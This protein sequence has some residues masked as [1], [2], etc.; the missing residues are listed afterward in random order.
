MVPGLPLVDQAAIIATIDPVSHA[1]GDLNT[2]V[3]DMLTYHR[4]TF[5]LISGLLA[6]GGTLDLTINGDI[7]SG[8]SYA[9]AITGKSTAAATFSGSAG[10]N[11][12]QAVIEI[13]GA[14]IEAQGLRYIRGT[15]T[16]AS[17]G[18]LAAVVVL[19][20]PRYQPATD[21]DLASVAEIVR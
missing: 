9:T 19:G 15:L 6:D 14:E 18:G 3:I 4:V 17:S 12:K 10:G 5:I 7:A 1:S 21:Y 20:V 8:G 16:A 2:D 11:G 13:D